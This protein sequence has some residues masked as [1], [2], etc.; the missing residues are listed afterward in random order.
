MLSGQSANEMAS[1]KIYQKELFSSRSRFSVR[2][3]RPRFWG[4][5]VAGSAVAVAVFLLIADRGPDYAKIQVQTIG[6]L[7]R[8]LERL[9]ERLEIPGMSAAIADRG[10]IVWSH[11]F[12]L[13]DVERGVRVSPET[14]FHLSSL[15]KPF[16]ATVAL[17]LVDEGRLALDEP[18]STFG[19]ATLSDVLVRVRHLLSHTSGGIPGT[20]FRYDGRAF[21]GL[22]TII[23]RITGRSFA[24]ELN[25]RII[26][27]LG[28]KH[29][30]PNPRDIREAECKASLFLVVTGTC[31]DV[32]GALQE[33]ERNRTRFKLTGIDRSPLDDNLAKGY[34]R[35]W[36]RTVWPPGLFG[37]MRPAVH[38]TTL[39][40]S[41]GLVASVV[42]VTRFSI[43]LDEGKL[44]REPTRT[45]AFTAAATP[46]GETLPYG[47]GWFVQQHN[48]QRLIWHFGQFFENSTLLLKIPDKQVTFVVLANSDGL[49]RRRRLGDHGNVLASPAAMLFLKWH[50]SGGRL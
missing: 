20:R 37:P 25:E 31:T 2:M 18:V 41:A 22:T 39:F 19:I 50:T 5:C 35:Q 14:S 8:E 28:L 32:Q 38:M 44:L 33:A 13:A 29:T 16:A 10:R 15:T 11:G 48:G 24:V 6:E 46:T 45:I 40:A 9:R 47:L 7:E 3:T 34:A 4:N 49:S 26:R 1:L 36:G 27:P 17:Q 21:G 30:G 23:E 42:D 12:G 43:A